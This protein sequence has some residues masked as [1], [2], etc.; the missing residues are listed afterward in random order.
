MRHI[1]I[2]NTAAAILSLCAFQRLADFTFLPETR[3]RA[4]TIP[5]S[6]VTIAM[7]LAIIVHMQK[8]VFACL[9]DICVSLIDVHHSLETHDFVGLNSEVF[10]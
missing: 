3:S 6:C 4:S 1:K 9:P 7:V 10:D 5:C 2:F 8:E